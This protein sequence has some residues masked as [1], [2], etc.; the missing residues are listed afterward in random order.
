MPLVRI[1]TS[2]SVSESARKETMLAASK[3][4]CECIGKPE[5]YTMTTLESGG[6]CMAGAP[7][8]ACLIEVKAIG[9][10]TPAVNKKLSAR[11]CDL[12]KN[13][14]GVPTD[15]V[16]ITFSEFAATHWGWNGSTFG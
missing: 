3:I 13:K 4:A 6:I 8:R 14:L 16:Y 7:G 12:A 10:L 1:L 9:G 2:D 5:A 11:L 15:R